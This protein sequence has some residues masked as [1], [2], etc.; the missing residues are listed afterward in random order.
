MTQ[1]FE[2]RV[3]V[4]DDE[5]DI[6]A[7]L[8]EIAPEVPVLLDTPERQEAIKGIII[9]CRKSGHSFVAV[10]AA[11]KVVGFA[12]ARPDFHEDGAISLRYVGTSKASR[13]RGIFAAFIGKLKAEGAP[14]TA[15]VLQGNLSGM[16]DQLSKIGFTETEA[17]DK[18]KKFRWDA[19]DESTT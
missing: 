15:S 11:G 10:D 14:I 4:R 16:A 9:E 13:R 17:G 19:E 7:V 18:E 8:E 12:L 6:L 2:I 3:A 5:T 1:K